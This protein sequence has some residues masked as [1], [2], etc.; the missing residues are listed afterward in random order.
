MT[1]RLSQVDLIT[2]RLGLLFEGPLQMLVYSLV[3]QEMTPVLQR[4]EELEE[5]IR[6]LAKANARQHA[7]ASE[8]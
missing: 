1:A 5:R 3:A 2:A 7:E 6:S 8:R 4:I